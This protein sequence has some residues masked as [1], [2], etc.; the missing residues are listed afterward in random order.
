MAGLFQFLSEPSVAEKRANILRFVHPETR[1]C[2]VIG[3]FRLLLVSLRTCQLLQLLR[4]FSD[5]GSHPLSTWFLPNPLITV[6]TSESFEK[7]NNVTVH[8]VFVPH[9]MSSSA[10]SLTCP[11]NQEY[12]V[13]VELGLPW[14]STSHPL[15]SRVPLSPR[16]TELERAGGTCRWESIWVVHGVD[17]V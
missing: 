13:Q 16:E 11:R 14:I 12:V 10:P 7:L 4:A 9:P 8:V 3:G 2:S 17:A 15:P 6:T 5:R 1:F